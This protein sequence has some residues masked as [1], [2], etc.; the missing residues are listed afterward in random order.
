MHKEHIQDVV[1]D[2]SNTTILVDDTTYQK[3]LIGS[4]QRNL[5]RYMNKFIEL[6]TSRKEQ[7]LAQIRSMVKEIGANE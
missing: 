6:P 1:T 2:G 5:Q 7:V 4:A 3:Q